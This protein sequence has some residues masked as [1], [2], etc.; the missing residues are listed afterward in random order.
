M[1]YRNIQTKLEGDRPTIRVDTE[2]M[3]ALKTRAVEE[4]LVFRTPS[5][6]LR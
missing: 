5:D 1:L 3:D 2:V 6:V 4:G